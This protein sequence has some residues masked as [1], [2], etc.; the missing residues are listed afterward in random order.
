[1]DLWGVVLVV[2]AV[3]VGVWVIWKLIGVIAKVALS[4]RDRRFRDSAVGIAIRTLGER[5]GVNDGSPAA[6]SRAAAMFSDMLRHNPWSFDYDGATHAELVE[7]YESVV[8]VSQFP[9]AVEAA[10]AI[11]GGGDYDE[12]I[13]LA[14]DERGSQIASSFL[15]LYPKWPSRHKVRSLSDAKA[16]S[17]RWAMMMI[18]LEE[19]AKRDGL[20]PS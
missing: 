13:E 19:R 11:T 1:M 7:A 4:G 8:R 14:Q 3:V 10:Y 17:G 9:I 16:E 18:H 2:A 6:R 5:S 20:L 12:L 15:A